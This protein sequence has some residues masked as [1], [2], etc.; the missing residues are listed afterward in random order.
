MAI[1]Q[2]P[3]PTISQVTAG[4]D[5]LLH[6]PSGIRL[7]AVWLQISEATNGANGLTFNSGNLIEE[8]QVIVG[9]KTQ[10]QALATQINHI[11]S[12]NDDDMA[13]QVV[14]QPGQAGY[15]TVFPIWLAEPSRKNP[16]QVDASAWDLNG[17][18][19]NGIDIK[20]RIADGV[21]NPVITGWYEYEPSSANL[22][23]I[24]KY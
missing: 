15:K 23:Y 4:D 11:Q 5:A 6:L 21:Q 12:V 17:P 20:L 1:R 7:H 24:A 16:N 10:R 14:G 22:G 13:V 9:D 2:A 18:G 19:I 8:V 3:L